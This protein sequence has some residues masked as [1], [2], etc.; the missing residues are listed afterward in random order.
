MIINFESL[1]RKQY[2]LNRILKCWFLEKHFHIIFIV[3]EKQKSSFKIPEC[4]NQQ[5]C[6]ILYVSPF[7]L[8]HQKTCQISDHIVTQIINF[9]LKKLKP[10]VRRVYY[11]LSLDQD[12]PEPEEIMN[13]VGRE[14]VYCSIIKSVNNFLQLS[15]HFFWDNSDPCKMNMLPV[16]INNVQRKLDTD[17]KSGKLMLFLRGKWLFEVHSVKT[18]WQE[19]REFGDEHKLHVSVTTAFPSVEY[20]VL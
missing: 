11:C 17:E 5:I 12:F 15:N 3:S 13:F 7:I 10:C 6:T 20:K 2:D 4:Y 18:L 14:H 9:I 8:A 1:E 16:L 19:L